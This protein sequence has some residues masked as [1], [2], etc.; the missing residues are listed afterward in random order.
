MI[1]AIRLLAI[2]L[3]LGLAACGA[4]PEEHAVVPRPVLTQVVELS[5]EQTVGPFVG[6]T[7]PRHQTVRSFQLAG[8]VLSR[9][10]AV[11]D[12]V[13]EGQELA[14]LDS[15]TQEFQLASA[16]ADVANAQ[17]QFGNLA[18][19]EERARA[20]TESGTSAQAQL[21]AATTAKQTAEAQLAQA[22]ANL[23]RAED[24][25]GYTRI[26]AEFDGVVVSVDAEVGQV[27]SAGQSILTIAKPDD[28][29]AVFDVPETLAATL[30]IGDTV[31]V[32]TL[33]A[34][35]QSTEGTVREIAPLAEGVART[36]RVRLTLTDPAP[37]FRLGSMSQASWQLPL[38]SPTVV[39]PSTAILTRD[40]ATFVW[41]ADPAT[42][43]V[44]RH[45]VVTAPAAT[46]TTS[47]TSGVADGDLLVVV[48]VNSLVE[49]QAVALGGGE[50][51]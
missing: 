45:A 46:G 27:V 28:R 23:T 51:K 24:Q 39:V 19:A 50:T 9:D 15:T 25:V 6:T 29:D 8:R 42:S 20:L 14:R 5:S 44:A 37:V 3:L 17:A 38:A 33:G 41:I 4:A 48:G 13:V 32:R 11:G 26:V 43:T 36:R 2:P 40:G 16:R 49:G 7:Q 10:V 18:A 22:S 12:L 47:I 31:V 34:S 35:G 1:R 30:A 21:D